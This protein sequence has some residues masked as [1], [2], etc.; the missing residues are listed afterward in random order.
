MLRA[1]VLTV[2]IMCGR[3][4]PSECEP[5]C[6]E[7][8]PLQHGFTFLFL[9]SVR[10]PVPYRLKQWGLSQDCYSTGFITSGYNIQLEVAQWGS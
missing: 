1:F 2:V 4:T 7:V 6:V 3:K 10:F 8:S 9:S 5:M